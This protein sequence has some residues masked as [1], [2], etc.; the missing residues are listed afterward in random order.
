MFFFVF[1]KGYSFDREF[2]DG[3]DSIDDPE[4]D[5]HCQGDVNVRLSK[6]DILFYSYKRGK[7]FL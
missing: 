1:L 5:R 6:I 4:F 7:L 3:E 2:S